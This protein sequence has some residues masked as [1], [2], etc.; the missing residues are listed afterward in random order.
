MT[1]SSSPSRLPRKFRHVAGLLLLCGAAALLAVPACSQSRTDATPR[2]VSPRGPLAGDEVANVELFR[3]ASPSVVNIISL[4]VQ[5]DLFS[6][7]VQQVPRG[8][9]TGFVWD[10]QGH[11]VTNYHVIQNA[12]GARVTL[13]DQTSFDAKLVGA[14]PDLERNTGQCPRGCTHTAAEPECEL[15]SAA[16]TGAVDPSRLESFRRLLASRDSTE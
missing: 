12:N 7:N 8:A 2:V 13:A 6:M 16:R 9:G 10:E 3:R 15:T 4:G 1:A 5:R 11:I 14:F